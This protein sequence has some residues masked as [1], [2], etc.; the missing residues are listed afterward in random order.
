MA[1]PV[2]SGTFSETDLWG[3][4][5]MSHFVQMGPGHAHS[6]LLHPVTTLWIP[7]SCKYPKDGNLNIKVQS[8]KE[9]QKGRRYKEA[10]LDTRRE[11]MF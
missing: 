5:V 6:P 2:V 11:R 10:Y 4:H 3:D 7:T 9:N 1:Q 8:Q